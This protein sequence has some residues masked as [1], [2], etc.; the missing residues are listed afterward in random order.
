[1]HNDTQA[2]MDDTGKAT[3][4][5]FDAV[6]K[7][8]GETLALRAV[9]LTVGRGEA[10]GL[11]GVNGAGKTT[12]IKCLLDFCAL[13]GGGIEVFGVSHRLTSARTFAGTRGWLARVHIK[14]CWYEACS[15]MIFSRSA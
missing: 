12:L 4:L 11:A 13:D 3:A 2:D 7:R 6:S 9:S 5:R 8:Y 10:F 15:R 14:P 1:M